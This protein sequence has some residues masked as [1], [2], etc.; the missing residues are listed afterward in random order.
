MNPGASGIHGFH[1]VRTLLRFTLDKGEIKNMD[2]IEL[3]ERAKG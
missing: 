1:K 3:G 2:A